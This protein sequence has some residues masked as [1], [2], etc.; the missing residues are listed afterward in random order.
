ML[1]YK[2]EKEDF[3]NSFFVLDIVEV[4][5]YLIWAND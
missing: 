3:D 4:K 1:I 2:S 5:W